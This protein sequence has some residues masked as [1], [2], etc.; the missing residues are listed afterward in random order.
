MRKAQRLRGELEV[1]SE[2]E[3]MAE[4]VS[5]QS[6]GDEEVIGRLKVLEQKVNTSEVLL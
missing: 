2:R 3:V 5:R 4:A 1:E 6:G